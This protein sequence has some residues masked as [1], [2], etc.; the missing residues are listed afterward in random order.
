MWLFHKVVNNIVCKLSRLG[1]PT[2]AEVEPDI[3]RSF[4]IFLHDCDID[5]NIM[6]CYFT[7]AN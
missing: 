3:N 2:S 6:I 4:I 1:D 5:Y 7:S